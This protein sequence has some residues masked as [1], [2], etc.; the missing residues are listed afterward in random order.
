MINNKNIYQKSILSRWVSGI[1]GNQKAFI[2]SCIILF[3]GVLAIFIPPFTKGAYAE[4][5]FIKLVS[6]APSETDNSS[7]ISS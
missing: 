3:F 2:G 6:A 4:V 5:K 7:G 1:I